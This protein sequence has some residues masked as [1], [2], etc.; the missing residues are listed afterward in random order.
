[1]S[2]CFIRSMYSM[3]KLCSCHCVMSIEKCSENSKQDVVS[4][5]FLS[6]VLR[7]AIVGTA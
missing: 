4:P 1:M 3:F 5:T 6:E 2:N 7:T